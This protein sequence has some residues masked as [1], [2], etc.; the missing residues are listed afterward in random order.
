MAKR[1]GHG[2]L[3]ALLPEIVEETFQKHQMT[4]VPFEEETKQV[5][6]FQPRKSLEHSRSHSWTQ[7]PRPIY[8]EG[9]SY[10]R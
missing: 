5:R 10:A 3:I 4:I 1:K 6:V 9:S 8:M 2:M 7:N